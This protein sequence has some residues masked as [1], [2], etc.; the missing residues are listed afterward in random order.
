MTAKPSAAELVVMTGRA[1]YGT[2]WQSD[3]AQALGVQLR[4]V[5]RVAEAARAGQD[6]ASARAWREDLAGL[7]EGRTREL[8]ALRALLLAD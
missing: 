8:A 6:Y 4:T 3:L 2:S 5:Q 7:V 1:L